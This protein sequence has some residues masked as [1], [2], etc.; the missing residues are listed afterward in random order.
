VGRVD[1]RERVAGLRVRSLG[2]HVR[3]IQELR[4][5]RVRLELISALEQLPP[6]DEEKGTMS[7]MPSLEQLEQEIL[8]RLNADEWDPNAQHLPWWERPATLGHMAIAVALV[9]A[10]VLFL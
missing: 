4:A 8:G 9:V 3:V 1:P 6:R 5:L 10:I 2:H 7:E